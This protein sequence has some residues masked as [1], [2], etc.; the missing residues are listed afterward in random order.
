MTTSRLLLRVASA[1]PVPGMGLLALPD[2]PTPQLEHY[3]LHT[4][5]AVEATGPDGFRQAAT[6]TVEEITNAGTPKRGLLLDFANP[7][8]LPNG[9]EIWLSENSPIDYYAELAD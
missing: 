9:A 1:L 6:A 8:A 7:V 3:A 4:T 5:L 2:G